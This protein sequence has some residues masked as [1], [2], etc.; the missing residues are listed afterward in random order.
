MTL[1]QVKKILKQESKKIDIY[2]LLHAQKNLNFQID[3]QYEEIKSKDLE[4]TKMDNSIEQ[5]IVPINEDE[6]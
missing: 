2:Q 4:K 3:N 6:Y 5:F 1:K